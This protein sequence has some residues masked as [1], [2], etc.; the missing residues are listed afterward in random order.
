AAMVA[1]GSK[2]YRRNHY[3][4]RRARRGSPEAAGS[5]RRVSV[6]MGWWGG[7]R[8]SS[9]D[10]IAYG[11]LELS[12]HHS[13][14]ILCCR[15]L[16]VYERCGASGRGTQTTGH[17]AWVA[18]YALIAPRKTRRPTPRLLPPTMSRSGSLT[19]LT[20]AGPTGGAARVTRIGTSAGRPPKSSTNASSTTRMPRLRCAEPS[21]VEPAVV[22]PSTVEK[23][24][25]PPTWTTLIGTYRWRASSTA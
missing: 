3:G 8:Q 21:S 10:A 7:A 11:P 19:A 25:S 1:G 14:V 17:G 24:T 2:P 22:V 6:G 4:D 16:G 18:Q 9:G 23:P 13:R 15:P 5:Q 12:R 20:S